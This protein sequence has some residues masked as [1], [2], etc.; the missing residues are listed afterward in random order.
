MVFEARC[1]FKGCLLYVCICMY[2]YIYIYQYICSRGHPVWQTPPLQQTKF[3]RNTTDWYNLMMATCY[4]GPS[5]QKLKAKHIW[6]HIK[7]AF[8]QNVVQTTTYSMLFFRSNLKS[9]R[10]QG[11]NW[12]ALKILPHTWVRENKCIYHA[13]SLSLE[14]QWRRFCL[15]RIVCMHRF[16]R[17]STIVQFPPVTTHDPLCTFISRRWF[18]KNTNKQNLWKA[19]MANSVLIK[20]YP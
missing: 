3:K 6:T 5:P 2:L 11:P 15:I 20:Q 7:R 13:L 14:P 8:L 1:L 17:A 19:K 10:T 16:P 12:M 18:Q 9:L 4:F